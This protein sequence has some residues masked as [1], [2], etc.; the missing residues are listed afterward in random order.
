AVEVPPVWLKNNGV[1][2]QPVSISLRHYGAEIP[3]TIH[4]GNAEVKKMELKRGLQRIEAL[5]PARDQATR[6]R[7]TLRTADGKEIASREVLLSPP[8]IRE[9]WLLPHSHVDIGYT[10]RQ[11]EIVQVQISNLETAMRL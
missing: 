5:I 1:A 4:L 2:V 7:L 11:E 6:E 9:M 10:H 8:R 3:V